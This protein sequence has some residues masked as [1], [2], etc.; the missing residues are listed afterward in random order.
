MDWTCEL[1][2][3]NAQSKDLS[4]ASLGTTWCVYLDKIVEHKGTSED[5]GIGPGGVTIWNG[6][7]SKTISG[8]IGPRTSFNHTHESVWKQNQPENQRKSKRD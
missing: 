5:L 2:S 1:R 3:S 7:L 6:S 4:A 8:S